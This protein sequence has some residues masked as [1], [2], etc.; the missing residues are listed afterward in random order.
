M[1]KPPFRDINQEVVVFEDSA[2]CG[3]SVLVRLGI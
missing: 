3:I 1:P 2:S